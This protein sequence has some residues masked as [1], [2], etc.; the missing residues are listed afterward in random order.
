MREM[1]VATKIA[2]DAYK[3]QRI[4]KSALTHEQ[5]EKL[6]HHV[7]ETRKI[8]KHDDGRMS[9]ADILQTLLKNVD[10]SQQH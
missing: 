2:M 6:R 7:E 1:R 5:E 9:F 8:L 4:S 10:P 3:A